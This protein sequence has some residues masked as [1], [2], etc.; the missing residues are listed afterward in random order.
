LDRYRRCRSGRARRRTLC[1]QGALEI[2]VPF[3]FVSPTDFSQREVRRARFAPDGHTVVYGADWGTDQPGIFSTLPGSVESRALTPPGASLFSISSNG[4]MLIGRDGTL[5]RAA[6]AGGAER[7]ILESVSD[8][9]WAPNGKDIAVVRPGARS[10]LEFPVSKVL[11]EAAGMDAPRVSPRGDLVAFLEHSQVGDSRGWV[12]V[13]DLPG[14]KRRL[15]QEFNSIQGSGWSPGGNEIWFSAAPAGASMGIYAVTL[16]GHQRIVAA[17]PGDQELQDVSPDGRVLLSHWHGRTAL[18]TL[19][20]GETA[21][22]DLSWLDGSQLADLSDDGKTLLFT[23][24]GEG[25]GSL[26]YSVWIRKTDGSDA[27]RLGEGLASALSPDG[28]WVL[29]VR[30]QPLPAQLVLLPTG[31]GEPKVVTNDAINHRLAFWF[32]DGKRFLFGGNEPEKGLR[33]YVQDLEG[34]RPRAITPE[35]RRSL[36]VRRPISPDGRLL[37][38]VDGQNVSLYPVEGGDPRPV[39]GLLE[40]EKPIRWSADGHSLYVRRTGETPI[41]LWSVDISTGR[42]EIWCVLAPSA[43]R[44]TQVL[45]AADGKSYVYPYATSSSDL[46]LVEGLK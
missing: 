28:K 34:G 10:R 36:V 33:L 6:L 5:A 44:S 22:R 13:V 11:C 29:A 42:R 39:P 43:S 9:D 24:E 26:S 41:R 45:V 37:V 38:V 17:G 19:P 16:S 35:I 21:E 18:M 40:L 25:S 1:G 14:K 3:S 8:A 7:E 46:Y 2:G 23:E 32:P 30:L 15:S 12:S 4:E 31:P 27:V 20:P